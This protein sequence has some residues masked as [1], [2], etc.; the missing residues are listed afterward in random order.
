MVGIWDRPTC[1]PAR[2]CPPLASLPLPSPPSLP[3]P[4]LLFTS[5]QLV[6]TELPLAPQQ[7]QCIDSGQTL[8]EG[9]FY[10]DGGPASW[11]VCSHL[12]FYFL[13]FVLPVTCGWKSVLW[14]VP[15]HAQCNTK[16]RT[17]CFKIFCKNIWSVKRWRKSTAG[18]FHNK[19][20]RCSLGK[21]QGFGPWHFS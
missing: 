6:W 11:F 9:C 16:D 18:G 13:F 2:L 14:L 7:S 10:R 15:G 8:S 21:D 5:F 19:W 17:G 20:R 12:S 3:P 1:Q 4:T